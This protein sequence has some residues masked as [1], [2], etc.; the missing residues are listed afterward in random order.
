M[1]RRGILIVMSGPSG[2]GKGSIR[3]MLVSRISDIVVSVSATT[4]PARAGEVEGTDYFFVDSD[5]FRQMIDA[6]A[7]LEYARVYENYYGTPRAFVEEQLE[8]G[9]DILLEIDIQGAMQVKARMP[10]GV[11]IFIKPPDK[12]E[13][14][15]RI[16]CRGKDS[17]EMIACRLQ[18][19][20]EE[21][22]HLP[23]YDYEILNDELA[24]AVDKIEAIVIAEHCRIR[25]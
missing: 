13:I 12:A 10:E 14:A 17:E 23:E 2:V 7:F 24:R 19:Y 6:E 15:R 8:A 3:E 16:R 18:A 25:K 4:R 20:D 9:Q 11:F 5:H 21:M 22:S 1:G